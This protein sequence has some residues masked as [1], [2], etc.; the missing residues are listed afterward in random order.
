MVVKYAT[1]TFDIKA[2]DPLTL[3]ETPGQQEM[4]IISVTAGGG[5]PGYEYSFNGE[6]FTSSN[7]YKIYKS[8]DYM[9]IVRDKNGCT[10][11]IT[12]PRILY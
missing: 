10:V 3:V 9:V 7:K 2:Y 4:N 8:G 6:P 1:A 12:V 5:A 11:T